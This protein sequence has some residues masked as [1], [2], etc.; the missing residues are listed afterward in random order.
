[1]AKDMSHL[2][3]VRV[4]KNLIYQLIFYVGIIMKKILLFMALVISLSSSQIVNADAVSG[5]ARGALIGSISGNA[6]KGAAIGATTGAL[7][8]GR[9][10]APVYAQPAPV[11]PQ[12]P[13]VVNNA[14]RGAAKGAVIGAISGNAGRGAAI[15]ATSGALLGGRRY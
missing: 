4:A 13:S 9:R 11:A 8:G 7:L 10:A 14:A 2:A 6:G 15:G 5:A 12:Q 3:C 1:M